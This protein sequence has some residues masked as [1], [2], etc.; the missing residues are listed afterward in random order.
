MFDLIVGSFISAIL[1]FVELGLH[2]VGL[3][4]FVLCTFGMF[5]FSLILQGLVAVSFAWSVL[6]SHMHWIMIGRNK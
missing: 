5:I 2:F 3:V 4:F 1:F 6:W